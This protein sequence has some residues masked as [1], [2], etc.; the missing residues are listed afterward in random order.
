MLYGAGRKTVSGAIMWDYRSLPYAKDIIL[1][2][3]LT[4]ADE[5]IQ[6]KK[7]R[8]VMGTKVYTGGT[9]SAAFTKLALL[10]GVPYPKT[11][12]LRNQM[13]GPLCPANCGQDF[14]TGRTNWNVQATARD[15]ADCLMVA[16]QWLCE[17]HKIDARHIFLMH[18]ELVVLCDE[19][20]K[21]IASWLMNVAHAWTW[22]F[23]NEAM[24]ITDMC[25]V[26]LF[27]DDVL[28]QR[29]FRKAPNY[30]TNS[31]SNSVDIEDLPDGTT[32][33]ESDMPKLNDLTVAWGKQVCP[34]L[35]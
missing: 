27:F 17:K 32:L 7:G 18:D 14:M 15:Q 3:A 16:F 2:M 22:A 35:Y 30:K 33:L 11:P 23:A 19:Q 6:Y 1:R 9:D 4:K 8:A 25:T 34:E 26:G 10:A 5:V 24:E 21:A 28:D 29:C 13:T 20:D 31:P 12:I